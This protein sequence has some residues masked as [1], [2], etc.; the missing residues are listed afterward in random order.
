MFP[1]KTQACIHSL[2][3]RLADV[4]IIEKRDGGDYVAD[5]NGTRCTA[6]FNLFAGRYYVDDVYGKL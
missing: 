3:G 2:N 6:I 4:E 1:F 5:Y